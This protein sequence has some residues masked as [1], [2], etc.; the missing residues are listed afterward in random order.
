MTGQ[1]IKGIEMIYKINDSHSIEFQNA[2]ELYL[3]SKHNLFNTRSTDL[4]DNVEY[5]IPDEIWNS[6]E[7]QKYLV[8]ATLKYL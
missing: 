7:F 6:D 3:L 1:H 2:I 4:A 5:N 8:K